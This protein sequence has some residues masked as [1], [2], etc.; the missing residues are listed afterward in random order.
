[1]NPSFS[2]FLI[3]KRSKTYTKSPP[4]K[5]LPNLPVG[6]ITTIKILDQDQS[7]SR[8]QESP[9]VSLHLS[10]LISWITHSSCQQSELSEMLPVTPSIISF[11][12]LS[13][14]LGIT[15]KT[16][17]KTDS[18]IR[19]FGLSISHLHGPANYFLLF[20]P[21][22]RQLSILCLC[23]QHCCSPS[24][25]LN[26]ISPCLSPSHLSSLKQFML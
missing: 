16:V 4:T 3:W 19:A 18:T 7:R 21:K 26:P 14:T 24:L 22:Y 8:L 12:R 6:F 2:S 25:P 11:L 23:W 20:P 17:N 1:M 13:I 9:E 5:Y 10:R 15:V